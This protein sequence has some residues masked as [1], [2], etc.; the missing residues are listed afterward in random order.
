[1]NQSWLMR[2]KQQAADDP[3][4]GVA[5][6]ASKYPFIWSMFEPHE[7]QSLSQEREENRSHALLFDVDSK[8]H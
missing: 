3:M 6:M 5:L 8:T 1:M 4:I 2:M 7:A